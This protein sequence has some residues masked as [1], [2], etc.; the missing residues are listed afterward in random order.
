MASKR[1]NQQA[2]A[3]HDQIRHYIEAA[4]GE[5]YAPSIKA[6]PKTFRQ[7][8]KLEG[9]VER[10]WGAYFDDLGLE[11]AK[12]VDWYQYQR[13]L[14]QRQAADETAPMIEAALTYL[15]SQKKIL[16][17]LSFNM[18]DEGSSIG[19]NAGQNL[20]QLP[21]NYEALQTKVNR[22]AV[23]YSNSLVTGINDT[24]LGLLRSNLRTSLDLGEDIDAA[25]YR[26]MNTLNDPAGIRSRAIART[27]PVNTYNRGVLLFGNDTGARGK[28]W[29][30]VLDGRTSL[31]CKELEQKYGNED[32]AIALDEPYTWT[33]AGGGSVEA[34]GAH[35]NCRS[36]HYL[37][38]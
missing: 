37:L 21:A 9:Q 14:N 26:I 15:E 11:L 1:L 30:S 12:L 8:V 17:Q 5:D 3:L 25:S 6:D 24:T 29:D 16:V 13:A 34:P 33:V 32:T 31:I 22:Q 20:Y 38:Y 35:V 18:F 27:E 10:Q 28:V 4:E 23:R 36:G 7:L 2:A 19:I